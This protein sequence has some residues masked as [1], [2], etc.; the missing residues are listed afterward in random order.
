M[1]PVDDLQGDTLFYS[2]N[3]VQQHSPDPRSFV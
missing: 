3:Q 1:L 2:I